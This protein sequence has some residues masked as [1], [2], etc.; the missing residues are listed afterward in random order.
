MPGK[1]I[2]T[3]AGPPHKCT[4]Q[5]RADLLSHGTVWRCDECNKDWVVVKGSQYNEPYSAWRPLTEH[6]KNGRDY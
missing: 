1:I 5:P 3:P 6:N 2:S 4:G